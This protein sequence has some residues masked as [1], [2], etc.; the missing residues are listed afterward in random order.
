MSN[1][2]IYLS[3]FLTVLNIIVAGGLNIS[4]DFANFVSNNV[5]IYIVF[6]FIAVSF[7]AIC[8]LAWWAY[9]HFAQALDPAGACIT[10]FALPVMTAFLATLAWSGLAVIGTLQAVDPKQFLGRFD[11]LSLF[12]IFVIFMIGGIVWGALMK[13][14]E[15]DNKTQENVAAGYTVISYWFGFVVFSWVWLVMDRML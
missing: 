5:S 13:T 6:A 3:A 1:Y 10:G 14:P 15:Y 11:E 8:Y 7:I 2:K 9:C 12:M 4:Q